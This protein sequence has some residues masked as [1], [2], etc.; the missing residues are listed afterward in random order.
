[1][2]CIVCSPFSFP[3]RPRLMRNGDLGESRMQMCALIMSARLKHLCLNETVSLHNEQD[4]QTSSPEIQ[5]GCGKHVFLG[6]SFVVD[7]IVFFYLWMVN[8]QDRGGNSLESRGLIKQKGINSQWS[9]HL[10]KGQD[11]SPIPA[12]YRAG[13]VVVRNHCPSDV[14]KRTLSN[15][16]RPSMEDDSLELILTKPWE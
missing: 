7:A 3:A 12:V 13:G 11:W 8:V 10:P 5:H 16:L 9:V 15:G 4:I 1:M 14:T 6:R 2:N